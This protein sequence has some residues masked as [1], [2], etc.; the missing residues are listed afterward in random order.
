ME[1]NNF[2]KLDLKLAYVDED[3][4]ARKFD[5]SALTELALA[6]L[7]NDAENLEQLAEKLVSETD[8]RGF[9][10]SELEVNLE[11]DE[12]LK[13]LRFNVKFP[14]GGENIITIR[15]YRYVELLTKQEYIKYKQLLQYLQQKQKSDFEQAKKEAEAKRKEIQIKKME[16]DYEYLKQTNKQLEDE[17]YKLKR[18]IKKLVSEDELEEIETKAKEREKHAEKELTTKEIEFIKRIVY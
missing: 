8:L 12:Y 17:N 11:Y 10:K 14:T 6:M 16:K 15:K 18:I 9:D 3:G 7:E 4:E 13:Y 5:E 1:N 2:K